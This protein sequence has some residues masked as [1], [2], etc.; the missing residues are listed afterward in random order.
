MSLPSTQPIEDEDP[1]LAERVTLLMRLRRL[2]IQ[3]TRVLA[4]IEAVPR[5]LFI[6]RMFQGR[7]YEDVALPIES[8]QTISQPQVVAWM[9]TA[10]DLN[11]RMRV[12]EIGTGSGYQTSILARLVRRVY[13]IE[14]H[15]DLLQLAEG[16]LRELG[17]TNVVSKLG[18]GTKGWP[19]VAPF[20]RIIVT[21]AA[22]EIQ[23]ALL[24][25]LAMGGVMVAPVGDPTAG[26]ILL[27]I[28]KTPEGINTQHLMDVRFVPLIEGK[29]P[30]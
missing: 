16:R 13:T 30:A 3:D 11:E 26:Q 8:G 12:L 17:F 18:D 19:E 23:A 28:E 29:V 27:R 21:A 9:T 6:P 25:Q 7:A 2:G 24:D 22:G 20:D 4:A 1:Y 10:L 5:E 15:R 14:R